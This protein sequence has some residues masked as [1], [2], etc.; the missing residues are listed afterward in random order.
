V[1]LAEMAMAGGIGATI[2]A[3]PA[4]PAHAVL[5]G[6][7]QARYLVARAVVDSRT[8][9]IAELQAWAPTAMADE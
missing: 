1:A 5:F 3:L 4:G 7:D 6:E 8:R 2:D 9:E